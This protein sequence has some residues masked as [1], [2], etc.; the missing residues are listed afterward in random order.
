MNYLVDRF[1]DAVRVNGTIYPVNTDFRVG[2]R[3]MCAFED[4]RLTDWEKQIVMCSLLYRDSQ[5]EDFGAA[6]A[7]ARKFLDCGEDRGEDEGAPVRGRVYSF[8]KDARYIYSAI[9][10]THGIDLQEVSSMHWWKFCSLF[11]DL[12]DDTT[13]QNIVSLRRRHE[14]GQLTKEERRLW[15]E[16]QPVLSLEEPEPD[17]ERDE[18]LA[19]FE[20][21]MKG[22]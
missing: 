16:L 6:C 20:R 2:L 8:S 12:R 5:P 10:Q 7:A 22:G 21:R 9:L 1:P 11:A 4:K 18:A 13:F 14:R 17:P 15:F 19:E 3:I